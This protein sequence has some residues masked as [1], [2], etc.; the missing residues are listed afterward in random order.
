ML[1]RRKYRRRCLKLGIRRTSSSRILEKGM[2]R[3]RFN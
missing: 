1:Q 2:G 3:S